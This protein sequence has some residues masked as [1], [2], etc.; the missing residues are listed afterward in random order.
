MVMGDMQTPRLPAALLLAGADDTR[1]GRRRWR[2]GAGAAHTATDVIAECVLC[3]SA[4]AGEGRSTL[5][6]ND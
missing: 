2:S 1:A 6:V 3:V 5:I 4:Q